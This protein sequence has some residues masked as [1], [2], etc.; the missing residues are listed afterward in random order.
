MRAI[1]SGTIEKMPD[2]SMAWASQYIGRWSDPLPDVQLYSLFAFV[3]PYNVT[4]VQIYAP[5]STYNDN[6]E[7]FYQQLDKVIKKVQKRN[8]LILLG[9][10]NSR[11]GPA[12]YKQWVDTA[13]KFCSVETNG[14]GLRLLEFAQRDRL[15][16][17]KTLHPH[18][19][20]RTT[21]WYSP[22]GSVRNQI[23]VAAKKL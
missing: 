20:S 16:L 4:I 17:A 7:E 2:T 10:W 12:T 6:Q 3:R 13:S 1:I 22:D 18:Q 5:T 8:I 14:R 9:D 19:K 11:A 21:T 15:T 23:D